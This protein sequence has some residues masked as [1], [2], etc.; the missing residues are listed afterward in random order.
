MMVSFMK[1]WFPKEVRLK[2]KEN[3][4]EV[5]KE[6]LEGSGLDSRCSIM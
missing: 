5:G 4:T 2:R 3:E 6:L 1:E